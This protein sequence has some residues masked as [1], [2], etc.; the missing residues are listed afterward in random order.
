MY[1]CIRVYRCLKQPGKNPGS[2]GAGVKGF[3]AQPMPCWGLL[4][5]S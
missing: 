4:G 2:F 1:R 3:A 5:P